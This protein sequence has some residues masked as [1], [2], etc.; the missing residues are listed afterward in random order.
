MLANEVNAPL[1]G[2]LAVGLM[3]FFT[4]IGW[5]SIS[6]TV[7]GLLI[8]VVGLGFAIVRKRG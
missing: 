2:V 7:L 3:V 1:F 6:G 4:S 8:L 5:L